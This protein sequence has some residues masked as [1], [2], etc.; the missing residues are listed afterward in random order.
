MSIRVRFAPSPT[1]NVHI[2][3][4]RVA[5]FNWL[6][7]RHTGGRFLLR[8]EDTDLERS[9]P[10]AIRNLLHAMDWMGIDY[11]EEPVYQS[12]ELPRHQ[13]AVRAMIAA[14]H[15]SRTGDQA[16]TVL[17]FHA[18]LFD[19]SFVT[20]PGEV[21]TI[22]VAK[23]EL[24]ADRRG[25]VHLTRSDTSGETFT[26][27]ISWDSLPE[28]SVVLADGATV[29][30]DAL[31]ARL[32]PTVETS[33]EP[34]AVE[35]AAG[36]KVASL[37]FRRR[38]VFFNDLVLG[39]LEKPLDSL[40]DLVIVRSDGSPVFHLANVVDDVTQTV[41][42]I[43][44]GN[45]HVENTFRH[46][47]IYKALGA[48]PPQ[49]G[50]FPMIVNAKGKPYSKRDGDAYVGDF[51]AKGYVPGCLFNF[52]ALCGW[53][54]GDG[55]ELMTREEMVAAFSLD[56]VSASAAQLN[57]EKLEWMNGQYLTALPAADLVPLVTEELAS[58]GISVGAI[59]P[60]WLMR[61][62][63]IEKDR[64]KTVKEFVQNTKYF[65]RD[66][67][68]LEEKAVKKVLQKNAGAGLATL[69]AIRDAL[70]ALPEWTESALE[71]GITG[72]AEANGLKMGDVAQP[73]RVAATGG[74]VSR[75]IWETLFLLG[76]DRTLARIDRVL[77]EIRPDA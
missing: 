55:R 47:F 26:R 50:H 71:Q 29:A 2:G 41:T 9:T 19:P 69:R 59:E 73:L 57:L 37:R 72:F 74:T 20:E 21:A 63:E 8:I 11:D 77:A 42:H 31:R 58:A 62:V 46:L 30:G 45:D 68:T 54:P 1:G 6:Y 7:A 51:K 35:P 64:L 16:P 34:V 24:K 40:R 32:A 15:A 49:Y 39:R 61:L 5:I 27:P 44:R 70:A 12:K 18:G 22:D 28:L 43:L 10:E 56:R 65:F 36:G 53:S 33:A 13:A 60:G 66:A 48:T 76:R 3:N 75:G 52:L 38:L 14:G 25:L 67:V 17:H 4:I 23:G